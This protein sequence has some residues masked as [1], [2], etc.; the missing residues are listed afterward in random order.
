M[1]QS[2]IEKPVITMAV[3]WDGENFN[4]IKT[5]IDN[6]EIILKDNFALLVCSKEPFWILKNEVVA[7]S[8]DN[9]EIKIFSQI[10]FNN[11]FIRTVPPEEQGNPKDGSGEDPVS[12]ET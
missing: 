10:E 11:D 1:I 7:K 4:E 9:G 5:F 8:M 12:Q 3:S 6:P 2:F